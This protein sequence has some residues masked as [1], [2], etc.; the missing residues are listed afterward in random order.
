MLIVQNLENIESED[1]R[2]ITHHSLL[3]DHFGVFNLF[4]FYDFVYKNVFSFKIQH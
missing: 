2:E 3:N 1:I 4:I